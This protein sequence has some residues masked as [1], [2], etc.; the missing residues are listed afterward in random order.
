MFQFAP[1]YV[2][3]ES[4]RWWLGRECFAK[5]KCILS[6]REENTME[7]EED[8]EE[9]IEEDS[10]KDPKASHSGTRE[11]CSNDERGMSVSQPGLPTIQSPQQAIQI[12]SL[13]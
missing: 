3:A 8:A 12:G 11:D 2:S 9:D 13:D 5:Q 6:T 1:V 10:E 7:D 4:M